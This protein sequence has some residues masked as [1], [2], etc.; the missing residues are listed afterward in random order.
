MNHYQGRVT[1]EGKWWMISIPALDGLTQA[2][3]LAD[4]DAAAR[5]FIAVTLDVAL[6]TVSVELT[7]EVAGVDNI[8]DRASRVEQ[9]RRQ[10]RELEETATRTAAL[11]AQE[12]ASVGVPV[13]DIGCVLGV[14]F[15][16][17]SQL[18]AIAS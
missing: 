16:R 17:A 12:L 1:R 5:E 14:S 10:A 4:V 18:L 15:Q 8:G 9:D 6:S 11:L 2:R 13:C 7:V 3:R